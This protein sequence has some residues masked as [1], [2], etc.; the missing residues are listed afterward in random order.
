[1]S[2]PNKFGTDFKLIVTLQSGCIPEILTLHR[3]KKLTFR[4]IFGKL[5]CTAFQRCKTLWGQKWVVWRWEAPH[6]SKNTHKTKNQCFAQPCKL[7]KMYECSLVRM[8][9]WHLIWLCVAPVCKS[10]FPTAVKL[11]RNEAFP[12]QRGDLIYSN[13]LRY[14][15]AGELVNSYI[16]L[17]VNLP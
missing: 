6:G 3:M 2:G 4:H 8:H 10:S 7:Y 1:M 9:I 17:R 14:C 5:W 12:H 16:A 15:P 11:G 13:L